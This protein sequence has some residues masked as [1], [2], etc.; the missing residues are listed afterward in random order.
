MTRPGV[1]RLSVSL[2]LI[3]VAIQATGKSAQSDK[4]DEPGVIRVLAAPAFRHAG[5]VTELAIMDGGRQIVSGSWQDGAIL[6]DIATGKRLKKLAERV[7]TVMAVSPAGDLLAVRTGE[8]GIGVYHLPSGEQRFKLEVENCLALVFSRDGKT[9]AT[10][11]GSSKDIRLWNAANGQSSGKLEGHTS[12]VYC[13]AFHPDGKSLISVSEDGTLRRWELASGKE[14]QRLTENANWFSYSL[15]LSAD[16]A[17]LAVEAGKGTGFGPEKYLSHVRLLDTATFKERFRVALSSSRAHDVAISPDGRY[18]A[19]AFAKAKPDEDYVRLWDSQSGQQIRLQPGTEQ[20]VYRVRFLPDGKTL[21]SAGGDG[22]VRMWNVADGAELALTRGPGVKPVLRLAFSPTGDLLAAANSD[23]T[24]EFWDTRRGLALHT[25][26]KTV[27][28]LRSIAFSPDGQSLLTL[29][30]IP[31]APFTARLWNARTGQFLQAFKPV[32]GQPAFSPDGKRFAA[33]DRGYGKDGLGVQLW[34]VQT[35]EKL[36]RFVG[37]AEEVHAVAFSPNGRLLASAS[38]DS[39]I[40]LWSIA[41]GKNVS[42]IPFRTQGLYAERL[43]FSPDGALLFVYQGEP[44]VV[45]DVIEVLTAERLERLI[46]YVPESG[47]TWM[48]HGGATLVV[49]LTRG[50][51]RAFDL[52]TGT[53]LGADMSRGGDFSCAEVT[54]D[55]RMLAFGYPN[56]WLTLSEPPTLPAPRPLPAKITEAELQDHWQMLATRDAKVAFKARCYLRAAAEQTVPLIKERIR[57]VPPIWPKQIDAWI[58]QLDSKSF[59]EREHAMRELE[60]A[61]FSGELALMKALESNPPLEVRQRIEMLLPKLQ[62]PAN[63]ELV[64]AMRAVVILEAIGNEPARAVLKDLAGGAEG[65][66]ITEAAREAIK[67]IK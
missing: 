47:A 40:R 7:S 24:V 5:P 59:K 57:P 66:P 2:I 21:A 23:G 34:D 55:G 38:N 53:A 52:A 67:R 65:S 46:A 60:K 51:F 31:D 11:D 1:W 48:A 12:W 64:R 63:P 44:A 33:G 10:G 61:G 13:L 62:A 35:G 50:Q 30:S 22:V 58:G 41:S 20:T 9:L 43:W 36:R 37:H 15:A 45:V 16:G 25:L 18:V 29:S 8:K 14:T 6:W 19:A 3:A 27:P 42:T 54:Q 56:G 39:T 26:A 32:L 4:S 49:G 28:L 17:T